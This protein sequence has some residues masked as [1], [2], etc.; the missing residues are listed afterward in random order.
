M[1]MHLGTVIGALVELEPKL[2][3]KFCTAIDTVFV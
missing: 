2:P 3:G 1:L